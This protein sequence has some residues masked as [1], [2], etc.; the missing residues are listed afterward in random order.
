MAKL[1]DNEVMARSQVQKEMAM[2]IKEKEE[3]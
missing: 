3:L 1:A 2:A